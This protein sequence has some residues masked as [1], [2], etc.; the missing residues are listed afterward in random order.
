MQDLT[1]GELMVRQ[2]VLKAAAGDS[3]SV[4]EV[5][6][7]LLGKPMQQTE[8]VVKSYTYHD[9][10]IQCQDLDKQEKQEKLP[11]PKPSLKTITLPPQ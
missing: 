5:L 9:F 3:K 6:D 7:R 11:A 2:L 1:L 4:Q 8:S 10:L